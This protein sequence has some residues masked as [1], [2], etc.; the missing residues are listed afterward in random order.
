MRLRLILT[1]VQ[2][3]VVLTLIAIGSQELKSDRGKRL[4]ADFGPPATRVAYAINAP[5]FIA[6]SGMLALWDTLHLQH[7]GVTD[8]MGRGLFIIAVG[9]LWFCV[10]I[11]IESRIQGRRWILASPALLKTASSVLLI[12]GGA[13]SGILAWGAWTAT[14]W[15]YVPNAQVFPETAFYLLWAVALITVYGRDLLK[16]LIQATLDPD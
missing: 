14:Q 3:V 7:S 1:A 5:A 13:F 6:R 16:A 12:L 8:T 15:R 10:G 2:I 9:I 4:Y 11:E